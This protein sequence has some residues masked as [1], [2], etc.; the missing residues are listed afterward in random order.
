MSNEIPIAAL[1]PENQEIV[2]QWVGAIGG[3]D[4]LMGPSDDAKV[5]RT[6]MRA[7]IAVL[8]G[9]GKATEEKVNPFPGQQ[10]AKG[11]LDDPGH[12]T[13][14]NLVYG[15][16]PEQATVVTSLLSQV[17]GGGPF[18]PPLHKIVVDIDHPVK[19]LE[20]STPGH[21]HL[22]IDK[23]MSWDRYRAVLETLT[24]VGVVEP[25]YLSISEQ[26]GYTA[27]RLPWVKKNAVE[28]AREPY[29]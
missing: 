15:N 17:P 18:Y 28:K 27:V 21:H 5:A 22:F 10:L 12:Y 24:L 16:N 20:S 14:E 8:D 25:G 23:P 6:Y 4:W 11:K 29:A 3:P 19:V 1:S 7:L 9:R 26:R 2:V 13:H